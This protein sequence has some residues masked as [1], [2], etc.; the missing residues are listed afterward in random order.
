M[1]FWDLGERIRAYDQIITFHS[2]EEKE[3]AKKGQ[4]EW[5]DYHLMK[6]NETIKFKRLLEDQY[7]QEQPDAK[8]TR[9]GS[10]DIMPD[11][12]PILR[13]YFDKMSG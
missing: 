2:N 1:S 8:K 11:N 9:S 12:T 13:H 6:A 5:R 10:G 4:N 3:C 7:N